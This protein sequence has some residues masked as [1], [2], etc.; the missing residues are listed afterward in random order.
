VV[1]HNPRAL[2]PLPRHFFVEAVDYYFAAG[3][4]RAAAEA[5]FHPFKSMTHM[6]VHED[7]ALNPSIEVGQSI[8][9]IL[10]SEFEALGIYRDAEAELVSEEK[11]WFASIDR[12]VVGTA[13]RDRVDNDWV[14]VLLARNSEGRFEMNNVQINIATRKIARQQLLEA[15]ENRL[16]L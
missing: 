1:F 10:K 14:Y 7:L 5:G 12:S 16:K 13:I 9:S 8:H 4:L 6:F 2:H 11:E 15:M 3:T